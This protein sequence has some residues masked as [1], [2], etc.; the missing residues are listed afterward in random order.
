GVDYF[1]TFFPTPKMTT[2]RLLLHV[3]A[4]RDYELH[5]LDF[6]TA[7]L[8]GSLHEEIW[9]RRPPGFTGTF[10]TGTQWS[11]RQPV[12]GLRQTPCEWHDT[13]RITLAALGFVPSTAD[14]SLFL[15]TDTLLPPFYVL[16]YVLQRFGFQFSSP[17]LTPLS[18]SHSLSAPP[19]D[20]SVEPSGPYPELVGCLMYLMTCTRPDLA[21]PLSLVACYVAPSRH[22]KV[23]WDAAKRVLRYLCSTLGM[24]LVLGGR[25]P[26]VLTGHADASRVHDSATQRS[27]QGYTFSLSS[28]SVSWWSTRSSSV[29]SSSCEAEIYAG[30]MAAQKLSWLTYLLTDLGEQPRSPPV[31]YVDNKAMIALCQEHRLEHRTKHIALRYFLARE[32]QQRG[33]LRLAYVATRANTADVFTKALPPACFALLLLLIG[34]LCFFVNGLHRVRPRVIASGHVLPRAGACGRVRARAGGMEA[35]KQKGNEAFKKGQFSAA[36]LAYRRALEAAAESGEAPR[37]TASLHSNLSCSLL[38]LGHREEALEAAQQCTELRE[39]WN[40]G[41]FRK[42]E[43]LFALQR[44]DEAEEAYRQAL[45]RAPDDATVKQCLL[46]ALEA[47]QGFLLRQLFAGREFCVG[48]GRNVIESQIFRSAQQMRNFIYLVGDAHSREAI[49]VDGA[50]DVEGI[51]RY[52]EAER[53]KLVGAVVTH[54]HFD[55]TGGMPPPPFDALG[56]KVP[57]IKEL[58]ATHGLKVYANKHDAALLRSKNGVPSDSIVEVQD[59]ATI[60]VGA[61]SLRFIHT[62][63]HTPGSQCIHIERAPGHDDGV[64]ISGDTLFIGSCGRLDL[65]DCNREAMYDSLQKLAALPPD[66]RVYPGHDY[67]G[68][69][70]SIGKEKATGFLRPMSKQQW[71]ASQAK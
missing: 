46:L 55:H 40:K 6:S 61:V 59:G 25:G 56:I 58:A 54:Y 45:D 24:G 32:L 4:R 16:V 65:P 36:A 2:L 13:L 53:V 11:L 64:L 19:S 17:Q 15:R 22:R 43:A 62:P 44:Y 68:A 69:F 51:L 26:I 52:A 50:W 30:T 14:P 70:T 48:R 57:G 12:Y 20:E 41:W 23:H 71:L 38:K 49:V 37:E 28:D 5:S 39:E 35:L 67:G 33:Q 1:Q 9:L 63:G 8:Q 66:T 21:Y 7:S 31:L 42:G 10:P 18:T 29:L 60:E 3:A 34:L 47:Q 27:S